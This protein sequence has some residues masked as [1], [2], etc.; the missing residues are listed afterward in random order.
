MRPVTIT[1]IILLLLVGGFFF[2]KPM[3]TSK[4]GTKQVEEGELRQGGEGQAE[5][6]TEEELTKEEKGKPE[7][8]P[9]QVTYPDDFLLKYD[10]VLKD[11]VYVNLKS[12]PDNNYIWLGNGL[13]GL[14]NPGY[15]PET[16]YQC[17]R[18][19]DGKP[20]SI[21][22]YLNCDKD[23]IDSVFYHVLREPM[24][25]KKGGTTQNAIIIFAIEYKSEKDLEAELSKI[26]EYY[27]ENR[28]LRYNNLLVIITGYREDEGNYPLLWLKIIDTL[29]K[30]IPLT[31]VTNPIE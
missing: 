9:A 7:D 21:N 13:Y 10:K 14:D 31:D 27:T 15:L 29:K 25:L 2:V 28:I 19:R 16:R 18:D 22:L 24:D 1:V 20:V 6:Q 4:E 11:L 12:D 8:K 3:L 26:F 30:K 23:K 5:K 17:T